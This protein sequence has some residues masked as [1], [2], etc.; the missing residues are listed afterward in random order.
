MGGLAPLAPPPPSSS[1]EAFSPVQQSPWMPSYA[2]GL[3]TS[4][5]QAA[6]P[7][8]QPLMASPQPPTPPTSM[9][10]SSTMGPNPPMVVT[11]GLGPQTNLMPPPMRTTPGYHIRFSPV[12][13]DYDETKNNFPEPTFQVTTNTFKNSIWNRAHYGNP[14]FHPEEWSPDD[15]H[16]DGRVGG[17]RKS[18][19]ESP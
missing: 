17:K 14:D 4:A 3:P 7:P 8:P 16:T 2:D 13:L 18:K 10:A 12:Q 15:E 5:P 11:S 1:S 19:K 9:A 6:P